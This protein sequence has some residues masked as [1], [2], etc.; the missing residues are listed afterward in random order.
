ML[1]KYKMNE[2]D[3][4]ISFLFFLYLSTCIDKYLLT[5][6]YLFSVQISY[7]SFQ[8]QDLI[9]NFRYFYSMNILSYLNTAIT[10]W[11]KSQFTKIKIEYLHYGKSK[12]AD[13]FIR[14]T[15]MFELHI[16]KDMPR[17][18]ISYV[19]CFFFYI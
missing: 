13:F 9:N 8:I 11:P 19:Y 18:T 3:I 16:H 10:G 5:L 4:Y 12:Q 6:D 1:T 7:S 14:N 17:E 2:N 15:G